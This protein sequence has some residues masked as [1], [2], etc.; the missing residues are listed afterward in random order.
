MKIVFRCDASPEIG[1]GH[2][3][4]CLVLADALASL[5]ADCAFATIDDS[6]NVVPALASSGYEIVELA[7]LYSSAPDVVVVDHY[8]LD[9][10]DESR[11]KKQTGAMIVAIDDLCDRF[12]ACD[13]LLVNNLGF[14][15]QD[16]E[17]LV[18]PDCAVFDGPE[19]MLL[20]PEF[21]KP[22]LRKAPPAVPPQ[23]LF[24]FFGRT[25]PAHLMVRVLRV[26]KGMFPNA[27]SSRHPRDETLENQGFRSDGG[28]T[29]ADEQ[30]SSSFP[31]F[32]SCERPDGRATEMTGKVP[33]ITAVIGAY[34][35]DEAEIKVLCDDLGAT[36]YIQT[37][38]M[39]SLMAAADLAVGSGGTAIWE[40]LSTDLPALEISHS[41]W[42]HPTLRKLHDQGYLVYIGDCRDLTDEDIAGHIRNALE[43]GL[44]TRH[45]PCGKNILE[46]ARYIMDMKS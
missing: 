7:E 15:A 32:P 9:W 13:A 26:L 40:R 27:P 35:P 39:A 28:D 5:G 19:F 16:Y 29:Y 46:L 30:S 33:K 6:S 3:S 17:A 42:Q 18:P 11:I 20:R 1:S 45:C 14:E 25:D 4:R 38:D 22:G 37:D 8:G 12:R 41:D 36:L 10:D 23:H 24:L 34:L 21:L 2:V 31:G 43:N 44:K